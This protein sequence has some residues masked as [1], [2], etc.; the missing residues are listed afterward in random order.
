MA[1]ADIYEQFDE[2]RGALALEGVVSAADFP[3]GTSVLQACSMVM[4]PGSSSI[5]FTIS[6]GRVSATQ[7]ETLS[8]VAAGG[9]GG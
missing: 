9:L 6:S 3:S 2:L 1:S 8:G 5:G 4:N 7:V